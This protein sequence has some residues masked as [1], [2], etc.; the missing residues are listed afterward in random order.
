VVYRPVRDAPPVPVWLAWWADSPPA[1]LDA[2][3]QLVRE[4][5]A[6]LNLLIAAGRSS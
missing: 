3:L 4:Q 1:N 5:Y 2:L 6:R